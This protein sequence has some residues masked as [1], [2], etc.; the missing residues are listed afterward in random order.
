MKSFEHTTIVIAYAHV[1]SLLSILFLLLPSN[2]CFAVCCALNLCDSL[3]RDCQQQ[4]EGAVKCTDT[5]NKFSL[6]SHLLALDLTYHYC[7]CIESSHEVWRIQHLI[8]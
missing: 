3:G 2:Y 1:H 7:S 4:A 6:D 8:W 5:H